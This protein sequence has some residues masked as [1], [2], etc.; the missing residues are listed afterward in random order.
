[1]GLVYAEQ[2]ISIKEMAA[3][4]WVGKV[5]EKSSISISDPCLCYS[6][7]CFFYGG[8]PYSGAPI[9]S[10][11]KNFMIG[12]CIGMSF[13]DPNT[14]NMTWLGLP[15]DEFVAVSDVPAPAAKEIFRE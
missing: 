11:G 5:N 6:C 12:P 15:A 7:V 14:I 3:K 10:C 8:C 2:E 13:A 4:K 1:M 9:W